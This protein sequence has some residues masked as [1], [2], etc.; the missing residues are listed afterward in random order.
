MH[1]NSLVS[2]GQEANGA[3]SREKRI[4]RAAGIA[5][6]IIAICAASGPSLADEIAD[7]Y[8][9][10]TVS[11]V[12]GHQVG[13]GYDIYARVLAPHLGR[14]IPGQPNV[15]VQNMVGA[16][17]ITAAN[18]L[19]NIASKDGTVM[20]TF[21]HTVAFEPLFGNQKA[22]YDA[23][24][25][26][27]I[28][29]MEEGSGICGVARASGIAKF[30]DLLTKEA[31]F[32]ATGATGPLGQFAQAVKNLVGAKLKV[33]YGYKGSADVKL[34]MNRGEVQG[35]C[36]LSLSTVKSF[37]GDEYKSGEFKP[38]IQL[39]GK[40]HPELQHLPNVNSYAK[41][42]EDRHVFGLIFGAQALGRVYVSPSGQPAARTKALRQAFV[43]TLKDEKFLADATKSQI[44]I[45]PMTGEEVEAMIAKLSSASSA[46]VARAKQAFTRE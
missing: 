29:N 12:V 11:I 15:I 9:G 45:E 26:S 37:W 10:K 2:L 3:F 5:G 7:F 16:S 27:W 14:H 4:M 36:G 20:A 44:D 23:A 18:W 38:V 30:D 6:A 32:G 46:V 40:P 25:L 22:Q 35:I 31:V 13:T 41:S 19:N 24:K 43:A 28:G 39:S 33:V 42:D 8:R 17:G 1:L 21:V 34:A